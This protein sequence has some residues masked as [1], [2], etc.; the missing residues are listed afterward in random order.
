MKTD[1]LV[2]AVKKG[3]SARVASLLDEDR[4]LL[5]A[6]AGNISAILLAL[7]HGHAD[8]V[9]LFIDRGAVLS[10]AEACAVGDEKRVRDLL[11]EDPSLANSF[12][13]DGYPALGLAIFFRQPQ[14]ARFLVEAGA[15]VNAAARNP[16]RVAPIHAAAALRDKASMQLLLQRGADPNA[17]QQEGVA[18]LHGAASR[19]DIEIATM[20]LD[21]GA[22]PY[23]KSDDGKDAAAFAEQYKQPHFAAWL[24]ARG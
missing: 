5:A 3:D 9:R 11:R 13:E 12:S 8:T 19:G 2:E 10:F 20:L 18:A 7:Y 24:R 4:G 14:I 1:E 15:D 21:A 17:R 23:I 22:D 6:K 16:Q